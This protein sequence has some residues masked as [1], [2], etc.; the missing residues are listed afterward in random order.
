MLIIPIIVA[1]S[2]ALFISIYL[3]YLFIFNKIREHKIKTA[4]KFLNNFENG[5]SVEDVEKIF[6]YSGKWV[7]DTY[8]P[9]K[10]VD[11]YYDTFSTYFWRKDGFVFTFM[12][13]NNKLYSKDMKGM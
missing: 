4:K 6:G 7:A 11:N 10:S 12:F 13:C 5:L 2:S 8:A 9:Y 3:I 1:G